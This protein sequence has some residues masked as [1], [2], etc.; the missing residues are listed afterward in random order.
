MYL[1]RGS[2]VWF[3]PG[4]VLAVSDVYDLA[5]YLNATHSYNPRSVGS[6][7]ALMQLAKERL[8]GEFDSV[9][10]LFHIDGGCC[11]RMVMRELVS[12]D[13]YKSRCPISSRMRRGWPP[14]R[15]VP[16][17]C[18]KSLHNGHLC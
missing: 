9:S 13:S 17:N 2:G 5:V 16:C 6:K 12:L 14:D 4:R 10:F 8:T 18:S 11:Q 15:L 3:D 7:T 1:A